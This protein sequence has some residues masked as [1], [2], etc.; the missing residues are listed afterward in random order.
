MPIFYSGVNRA[1]DE[2]LV[3]ITRHNVASIVSDTPVMTL[4]LVLA[5]PE[6]GPFWELAAKDVIFINLMV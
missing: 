1:R 4:E 2:K 6:N 3:P 5:S